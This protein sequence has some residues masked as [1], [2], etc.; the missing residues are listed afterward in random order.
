MFTLARFFFLFL[1]FAKVS[2]SVYGDSGGFDY[3]EELFGTPGAL[4]VSVVDMN[5][6][7]GY[8]KINGVDTA[9]PTTTFSWDWGDGGSDESFFPVEHVYAD[10]TRNYIV[11]VT[12]HYP[13]EKTDSVKLVVRWVAPDLKPVGLPANT[14]VTIPQSATSLTSRMTGYLVPE[15]LTFFDD[16]YFD[17]IPRESVEYILSV[18][19]GIQ[20]ELSNSDV[21]LPG[22]SFNQ[23]LMRDPDFAGMYSLW[24]TTP[25]CFGVGDYGFKGSIEYSSFFHEMGHN[26]TLNSPADYYYGGKIDGCANAIFSETMAQIFQHATGYV[27]LNKYSDYGVPDDLATEVASSVKTS[28][29]IVRDSYEQYVKGG[30]HYTS[31]NNPGTPE[32][33]TFQIFMT[34]AYKFFEHAENSGG[35]Y[36]IPLKR[37]MALLQTFDEDMRAKYDQHNDTTE[38]ATFRATLMTAALSYGFDQDLRTEFKDLNFPID[39]E[40]YTDLID[41]MQKPAMN[42]WGLY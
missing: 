5:K 35:G 17:I 6:E 39:D 28:I 3:K 34:I 25:V 41:S 24:F 33:E 37:M 31:W 23:V 42:G 27:L 22:G 18:A 30:K 2:L 14:V 29:R 1:I 16:S 19:A 4:S 38:A 40:E 8:V 20:I 7:T 13:G 15:D 12:S 36:A 10:T 9:C 21:F 32:D 11:T 26:F